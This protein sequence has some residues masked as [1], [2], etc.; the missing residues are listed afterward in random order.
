MTKIKWTQ[1]KTMVDRTLHRKLKNGAP[2]GYVAPAPLVA[3]PCYSY[4]IQSSSDV[5]CV[6]VSSKRKYL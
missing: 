6:L 1:R 3:L 5:E 2:A 4:V